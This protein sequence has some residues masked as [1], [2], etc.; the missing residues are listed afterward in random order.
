MNASP[1]SLRRLAQAAVVGIALFSGPVT[2]GSTVILS[3]SYVFGD[4][5]VPVWYGI[6]HHDHHV[7]HHHTPYCG[8]VIHHPVP[9]HHGHHYG[10]SMHPYHG[11]DR[12]H[13]YHRQGGR[14][15]AHND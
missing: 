5:D 15:S 1:R 6:P 12:H 10:H 2:A 3:G 8:H 4:H 9:S 11:Y 13:G 7:V 14:V